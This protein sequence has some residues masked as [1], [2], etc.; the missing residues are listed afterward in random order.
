[1]GEG[2]FGKLTVEV[3]K[4]GVSI[5]KSNWIQALQNKSIKKHSKVQ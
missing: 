5:R 1:M 4:F 2:G 3:L